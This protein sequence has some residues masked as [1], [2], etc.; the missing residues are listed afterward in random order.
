MSGLSGSHGTI[1]SLVQIELAVEAVQLDIDRAIPAGLVVNELVSNA[2]KHGF[3]NHRA[4]R[5]QVR[6]SGGGKLPIRIAVCDDG[7]GWSAGFDPAESTSLGLRLVHILAKQL[8]GVVQFD[9]TGGGI[10]CVLTLEA[11]SSETKEG[12]Q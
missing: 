6:L 5:I 3:P 7:V 10:R 9:T 2:F 1:A 4:G 11:E 12:I 8:R